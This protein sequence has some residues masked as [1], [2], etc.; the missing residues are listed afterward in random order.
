MRE[1]EE[2]TGSRP[3]D[4]SNALELW[5]GGVSRAPS[6]ISDRQPARSYCPVRRPSLI[7]MGH[8][9]QERIPSTREQDGKRRA[10]SALM[11][12][13]FVALPPVSSHPWREG[14]KKKDTCLYYG[15]RR[16][17]Q[18]YLGACSDLAPLRPSN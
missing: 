5:M 17:Q 1:R 3:M 7:R 16:C 12:A 13:T 9:R 6:L 15:N 8:E 10:S 14:K 18:P 11:L 4:D 2:M